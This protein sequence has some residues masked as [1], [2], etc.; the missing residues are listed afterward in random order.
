MRV[1]I[2]NGMLVALIINMV[3][4]KAI[5]L[6]QGIMVR[7]VSGDIWISTLLAT[8]QGMLVAWAT[9][10][11][12]RSAPGLDALEL[13]EQA[14]SKWVARLFGLIFFVF[15]L[16]AYCTVLITF[17]FHMMDY[18]LPE[19]PIWVFIIAPLIVGVYGVYHGLEVIGRMAFIGLAAVI[20]LNFLL[21][22]GSLH[23]FDVREM[24]PVF[25]SGLMND[26]WA[27][28]HHDTDWSM[29]TMMLA[30]VLPH[31]RQSDVWTS[32]TPIGILMGGMTVLMWPILETGVL[33]PEMT[34]QYIVSCMQMARS[35]E[36]GMFLHRYEMIMVAFFAVTC[37]VQIMLLVYCASLSAS[38]V[39]GLKDYRPMTIPVALVLNGVGYW[40]VYDH[41]RAMNLLE[42]VWPFL[43]LS[44]S[45]SVPVILLLLAYIHRKKRGQRSTS[46]PLSRS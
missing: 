14:A 4:S 39:F 18:F 36:I 46:S 21:L 19:L 41:F 32:S 42:G 10:L 25:Q 38:R 34:A 17:V 2:T 9:A 7:E 5:G 24:L 37:F 29:A 30:L 28:R 11:A 35:A 45:F 23:D 6:T 12:L 44:I 3:Y 43:A 40:V 20:T 22:V 15:F 13:I 1:Q 16:G 31:V 33:S 27:S 8:L 26:I